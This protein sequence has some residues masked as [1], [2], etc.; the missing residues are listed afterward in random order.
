MSEVVE[1]VNVGQYFYDGKESP[2]E[3]AAAVYGDAHRYAAILRANPDGL[4]KGTWIDVPN[5]KGRRSVVQEGE[6]TTQFLQRLYSN[7]PSHLYIDNYLLWNGGMM[8]EEL[9][10][11]QVY[12]PE[13]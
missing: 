1:H 13:R 8:A 6:S 2:Q 4:E 3:V 10:G 5:K 7:Q 9:V 11:M 12:V